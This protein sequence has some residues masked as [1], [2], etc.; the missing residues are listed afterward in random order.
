MTQTTHRERPRVL[1]AEVVETSDDEVIEAKAQKTRTDRAKRPKIYRSLPPLNRKLII[2]IAVITVAV[3]AAIWPRAYTWY[4][5]EQAAAVPFLLITA[6]EYQYGVDNHGTVTKTRE[7]YAGDGNAMRERQRL[8][9]LQYDETTKL[10]DLI[11]RID[12]EK[13]LLMDTSGRPRV[14]VRT[15]RAQ[16]IELQTGEWINVSPAGTALLNYCLQIG[17]EC[18]IIGQIG[19]PEAGQTANIHDDLPAPAREIRVESLED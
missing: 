11:E 18:Q 19:A 1:E 14:A 6:G 16:D 3:F 9:R 8:A 12:P 13:I 10:R 4:Q 15:R 17:E 7:Y 2:A 5:Y